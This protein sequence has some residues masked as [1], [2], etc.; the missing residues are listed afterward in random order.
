MNENLKEMLR[1]IAEDETLQEKM[2]AAPGP[3]EAYSLALSIQEGYTKEEFLT[4]MRELQGELDKQGE[5]S[6]D[7]LAAVSGGV[8]SAVIIGTI[9]VT[10]IG[11]GA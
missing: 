10:A 2:K 11:F 8:S 3:D 7:D 4:L 9:V 1:K 5:L 6:D